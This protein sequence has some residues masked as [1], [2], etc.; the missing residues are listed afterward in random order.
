MGEGP[1]VEHGN[2]KVTPHALRG[3]RRTGGRQARSA[4][5]RRQAGIDAGAERPHDERVPEGAG[6]GMTR[7]LKA[8]KAN[9]RLISPARRR[10]ST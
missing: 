8:S 6:V 9:L 4:G 5:R 1:I 10:R 2:K 3:H 7:A